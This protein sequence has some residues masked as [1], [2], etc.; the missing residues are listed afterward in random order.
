MRRFVPT[1]GPELVMLQVLDQLL[2]GLEAACVVQ[3][4]QKNRKHNN[5]ELSPKIQTVG[6]CTNCCTCK[7]ADQCSPGKLECL[8]RKNSDCERTIQRKKS[9]R[10]MSNHSSPSQMTARRLERF[11]TNWNTSIVSWRSCQCNLRK[12]ESIAKKRMANI[13]TNSRTSTLQQV[14]RHSQN[15]TESIPM[16]T[17]ESMSTNSSNPSL[18]PTHY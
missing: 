1:L 3:Q 18:L 12:T 10:Q 11:H 9:E 5:Q 4:H 2:Q 7:S 17:T 14:C 13:G 6:C 8:A 15:K 16:S